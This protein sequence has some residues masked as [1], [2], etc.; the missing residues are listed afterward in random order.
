VVAVA[1]QKGPE[2]GLALLNGMEPPSWLE[3]SYLWDA[4]LS[5]LNRRAGRKEA[6][7]AHRERALSNSPS[8]TVRDAL[9]RRLQ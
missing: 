3:A 8:N 6:A 1:E 5:D 7:M 9:V 2:A 4:V